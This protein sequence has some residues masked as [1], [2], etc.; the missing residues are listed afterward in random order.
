MGSQ[1]LNVFLELGK[2]R[3]FAGALDW[4]GWYRLGK[5]EEAAVQELIDYG[6]RYARAL[7]MVGI[8]VPLPQN[9]DD[10]EICER[11]EGTATTDFGAPDAMPEADHEPVEDQEMDR[12]TAILK[13]SWLAL[14]RAA[15][16]AKGKQLRKGP[17][18]G[19]RDLEK[20][21]DHT[22]MAEASYLNRLGM[23]AGKLE[24]MDQAEAQARLREATLAALDAGRMG[25][26]PKEGPRGGKI[27][28]IRYYVRRAA[29]HILDHAWEIED[30][31]V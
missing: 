31:I 22:T 29:W 2:K 3:V 19:G 9:R 15:E 1:K 16:M 26:L 8:E 7:Q 27:W 30:R 13:A 14:D 20:I 18:G 23:K 24:G 6:P 21:I 25:K 11:L 5:D 10:I 17:R 12:L 28:P 4:P